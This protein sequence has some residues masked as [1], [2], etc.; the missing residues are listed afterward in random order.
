MLG[1]AHVAPRQARPR[2]HARSRAYKADLGLDLFDEELRD[3][4]EKCLWEHAQEL[5]KQGQTV[6]LEYGF[7][8]RWERDEK[9]EGARA[10]GAAV[11]LH[12]LDVP[13]DELVRRVKHRNI[14]ATHGTALIDPERLRHWSTLFEAPDEAELKLYDN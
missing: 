4:L 3:R 10:L 13:L 6:I 14:L 5:L 11:E 12:Y 8:L 1:P 2:A 9:R 7:W